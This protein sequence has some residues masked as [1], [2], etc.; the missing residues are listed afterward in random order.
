M[1]PTTNFFPLSLQPLRCPKKNNSRFP[2]NHH[3]TP[4]LISNDFNGEMVGVFVQRHAADV[5]TTS[6]YTSIHP[7]WPAFKLM[8]R[9]VC[10]KYLCLTA[11]MFTKN[12]RSPKS[13]THGLQFLRELLEIIVGLTVAKPQKIP[14]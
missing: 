8:S 4:T 5:F 12:K 14:K 3:T 6:M 13:L 11:A 2:A 7:Y 1:K 10:K 9:C